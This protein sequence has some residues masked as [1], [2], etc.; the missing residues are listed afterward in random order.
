MKQ[1][2]Y[3]EG[4]QA[5]ENFTRGMQTVFRSRKRRAKNKKQQDTPTASRKKQP[6][7]DKD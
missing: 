4:P 1:A 7:S 6:K 2:E 5:W 3:I